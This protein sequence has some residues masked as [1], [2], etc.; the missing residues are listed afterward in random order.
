[1]AEKGGYSNKYI[2][3]FVGYAPAKEPRLIVAI[4]IVDPKGDEYGGSAVA[5]PVFKTIMQDSLRILNISPDLENE[6]QNFKAKEVV[7]G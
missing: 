5:A 1:M 7:N 2:A 4:S 6:T 3:S